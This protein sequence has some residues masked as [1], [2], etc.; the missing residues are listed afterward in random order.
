MFPFS[1]GSSWPRNWTGV[2]CLAGGFFTSWTTREA[3]KKAEHQI[4]CGAGEDLLTVPWT[5]RRSNQSILKET[6]PEYSLEGLMK[7]NFQYVGYLIWRANSLE[8]TLMW[9]KIESKRRRGG[10]GWDGWI[11]SLTWASLA[12]HEQTLET[13]KDRGASCATVHEVSKSQTWLRDWATTTCSRVY[14]HLSCL[15]GGR[16]PV[17]WWATASLF[18]TLHL[19]TS[20]R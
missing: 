6:N 4:N 2:S 13:M 18:L 9:G 12:W 19:E 3:R 20:R 8:K 16:C 1:R 10:K 7:L 15:G 5:A 14:W 17:L 11:A